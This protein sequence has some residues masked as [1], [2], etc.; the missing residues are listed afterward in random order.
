AFVLDVVY[1]HLGPEGNYAGEF[2]PLYSEAHKSP[3]GA[4]LNFD[5]EGAEGVR[6]YFVENALYWLTEYHV[7]ALRLDAVHAI[8]DTSER[9][10]LRQLAEE[11]HAQAARLGRRAYLIAE[12]DLN[13]V[14]VIGAAGEGGY[15]VDAQW[16]DDFHHSLHAVVTGADRGY[17]GDFGRVE[18]LAKAIEEGF[19][20][21]GQHS[22]FRGRCHGTN[23]ADRPGEQFVVCIQ[24]HDQVAN[25][26]W[27]DRLSR[28]VAPARQ[29]VAAALYLCGAPNVPMLFMGEEWAERAPFLYFTS[30]TDAELGRAVRV[31]REEEYNSFVRGEGETESTI[32]GFSDP[33][34]EIT[35]VRSKIDWE[36]SAAPPH[37]EMLAFYRDLLSLRRAHAALSNCDKARTRVRFD[38]G[39]RWLTVERGDESGARAVLL[40]N[41]AGEAQTVPLPEGAWRL[42]VWSGAP[43]YG[44]DP[45][46]RTPPE[47]TDGERAV[48]LGGWNVAL[49]AKE[50]P[51]E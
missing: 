12:S 7:D 1:N 15:G 21:C 9:H 26:Y 2:M 19:V 16:S 32:G 42:A 49:Y 48:E 35:F 8:A 29:R 38:E 39:R 47:R 24:N 34:S 11:F 10:L 22:E 41:L 13:D 23:S 18:D 3:W 43:R 31:G 46:S 37:A 30:H 51:G 25:G 20:Y 4:G 33:Q 5:G 17:F 36:A 40:C 6:R 45:S 44:G 14:R 27:G 28:V 50:S